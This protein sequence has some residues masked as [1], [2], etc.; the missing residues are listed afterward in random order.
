MSLSSGPSCRYHPTEKHVGYGHAKSYEEND[1]RGLYRIVHRHGHLPGGIVTALTG[2]LRQLPF[3]VVVAMAGEN[4][5]TKYEKKKARKL[6][7][8]FGTFGNNP[9]LCP[10]IQIS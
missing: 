2:Y 7:G 4:Q 5:N 8:I 9:Y 6:G 10:Q 1:E 3:I